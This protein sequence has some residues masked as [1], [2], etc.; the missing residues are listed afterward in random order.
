MVS[1]PL[2]R[3]ELFDRLNSCDI[4]FPAIHGAFGEDGKLQELLDEAG[5]PYV[6]AGA[7]AASSAYD[8]YSAWVLLKD[9]NILAVPSILLTRDMAPDVIADAIMTILHEN[10][11]IVLKPAAGGS[12]LGVEVVESTDMA[13]DRLQNSLFRS[14]RHNADRV[15]VQPWVAGIEFTIVVLEGPNGPVALIPLEIERNRR[16]DE[17]EILSYRH[18]YLPNDD[19]AYPCPPTFSDELIDE[20]RHTAERVFDSMELR[21]FARVDG[22][23]DSQGH[24]LISDINVISGMEQNSFLF[25]QAAQVGLTHGDVL[26][27][28]I[29]S[30]SRRAALHQE[31]KS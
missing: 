3:G 10:D 11:R 23:V 9:A 14:D 13:I 16:A 8:K 21:D 17:F 28:I 18:K 30:A 27:H 15:V 5:V 25:I 20:I 26:S 1:R 12:S 19:T 29:G 2:S 6:G 24:V 22:W 4:A 7:K 31:E